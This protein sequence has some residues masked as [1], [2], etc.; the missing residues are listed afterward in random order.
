MRNIDQFSSVCNPTRDQ[1]PNPGMCSNRESNQ[2]PFGDQ[3]DN[4]PSRSSQARLCPFVLRVLRSE[5]NPNLPSE[6][7]ARHSDLQ[8][9]SKAQRKVNQDLKPLNYE[10]QRLGLEAHSRHDH[11]EEQGLRAVT[12]RAAGT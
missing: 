1:I 9:Q 2:L 10:S 12:T 3:D 8:P 7:D 4:Q 6:L 5:E 11:E